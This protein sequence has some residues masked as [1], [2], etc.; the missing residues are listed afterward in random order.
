MPDPNDIVAKLKDARERY[1]EAVIRWRAAREEAEKNLQAAEH[2][3]A[4]SLA[5]LF[6]TRPESVTQLRAG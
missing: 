2:D 3:V 4:Q 6:R 1:L 5:E